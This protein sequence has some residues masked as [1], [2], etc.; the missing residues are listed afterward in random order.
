MERDRYLALRA[1]LDKALEMPRQ[2]RQAY[3]RE[4]CGEDTQ[5]YKEA[6]DLAAY[7]DD[8][9]PITISDPKGFGDLSGQILGPYRLIELIG[10]GGM[11]VVYRAEQTGSLA[12]QVAVKIV[13]AGMDTAEVIAR[14]NTER[15]VLAQMN[16][17]NIA[18]IFDAGS[19]AAGRPYFVM[20]FVA[21]E[22]ITKF[23]DRLGL[24]LRTRLGLFIE[25]CQAVQHAHQKGVIHRD[26][27]PA[28][29]LVSQENGKYVPTVIDFGIA[30]A[31]QN[32]VNSRTAYTMQG[33]LMG[34][35]A[36]MS[37]EQADMTEPSVDT[38]SDIYSLGVLLYELL[39]G[40]P[41]FD[42][43]EL[44]GHGVAEIHRI[45][46][47][48]DPPRP[49]TRVTIRGESAHKEAAFRATRLGP[50]RKALRG[51]LDWITMRALE[52]D[53]KRRYQTANEFAA[54]LERFLRGE[55]VAAGPPSFSYRFRK[56]IVRNKAIF[57]G[58]GAVIVSLAL[59]LVVSL[60]FSRAADR[61]REN[62]EWQ[63]YVSG[64]R[65]AEVAVGSNDT[66]TAQSAL[67]TCPSAMRNWEWEYLGRQA[68][69]SQ[70]VIFT[71]EDHAEAWRSRRV[72]WL[73]ETGWVAI[74]IA[75]SRIYLANSNPPF[76]HRV[77]VDLHTP[78][79]EFAV[80]EDGKEIV[81]IASGDSVLHVIDCESGETRLKISTFEN[82]S[83]GKLYYASALGEIL[84]ADRYGLTRYDAATGE[85]RG[86]ILDD[87]RRLVRG[88]RQ[89]FGI[90]LND[91]SEWQF[92]DGGRRVV[93]C[94][95]NPAQLPRVFD[96]ISGTLLESPGNQ[97]ERAHLFRVG[98]SDGWVAFAGYA[99]ADSGMYD[100][101]MALGIYNR[102]TSST[103]VIGRKGGHYQAI[104]ISDER[105]EL[106]SSVGNALQ[107]WSIGT[108]EEVATL[109][110]HTGDVYSL[111]I[112]PS[113][114]N[115]VSLAADG[116]TRHW[117]YD[118]VYRSRHQAF[119][120][121]RGVGLAVDS[122]TD[123]IYLPYGGTAFSWHIDNGLRLRNGK[124]I[125]NKRYFGS[126]PTAWTAIG[127]K[128]YICEGYS[129]AVPR[130]IGAGSTGYSP[131]RPL[132]TVE[133]DASGNAIPRYASSPPDSLVA[134]SSQISGDGSL[135]VISR[136]ISVGFQSSEIK[137][138]IENQSKKW[139]S[140]NYEVR[141]FANGEIVSVVN[142]EG[143]E[144]TAFAFC[145]SGQ[146][147]AV[148]T[149]SGSVYILDLDTQGRVVLEEGN[150]LRI[151]SMVFG[152]DGLILSGCSADR[153][154]SIWS[155]NNGKLVQKLIGHADGVG[156]ACL[157]VEH[158]RVYTRS[159]DGTLRSWSL[160]SGDLLLTIKENRYDSMYRG[161]ALADNGKLVIAARPYGADA[162]DPS[163][164]F[165]IQYRYTPET[166]LEIM[167]TGSGFRSIRIFE[168]AL[169]SV[170]LWRGL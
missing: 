46:R 20:E 7:A 1:L 30:K 4:Q 140:H 64:I 18:R 101:G 16:H 53:R 59:G 112:D 74:S 37:P 5:L 130:P 29:V 147:L 33:V 77:L 35:P 91:Y 152:P 126:L 90:D 155:T 151:N 131:G 24:N 11:G 99:R 57:A 62:A 67:E 75:D 95:P 168:Y 136:E 68:D 43:A 48:V 102:I 117:R 63:A 170:L 38:T 111:D 103:N 89:W 127:G 39:V 166:D 80:S 40:V 125:Y 124:E 41:P 143:P 31:I 21:G 92:I 34:T 19:T 96:V 8:E 14:F 144:V 141:R 158:D 137:R 28:N 163:R 110:G 12:R 65:L 86:R 88:A 61:A 105:S 128:L 116:T 72:E 78:I 93:V 73:G 169:R 109:Q 42:T 159:D 79:A 148:G 97:I 115:L 122:S 142:E 83:F 27:K 17:P 54:D 104:E 154:I 58:I 98:A 69:K 113:G 22:P 123:A 138:L 81:A 87:G 118:E 70:A 107:I 100:R 146:R 106:V 76:Q 36:Y 3:L 134:Q 120:G 10:E 157:D 71:F 162:I 23:C 45:L 15:Q 9:N 153:T 121:P 49:S 145:P 94:G 114:N 139:M 149:E 47:E 60:E 25:T 55:V 132:G 6:S 156:D 56:A 167:D 160:S 44:M 85:L 135:I 26:I 52:K 129:Q 13:K 82:L 51:E 161:L 84:H 2:N 119:L 133:F 66:A 50:W 150:T 32:D 164:A 165:P 108:G